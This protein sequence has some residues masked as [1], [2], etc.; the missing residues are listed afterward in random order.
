MVVSW[1]VREIWAA[2]LLSSLL[3]ACSKKPAEAPAPSK[4]PEPTPSAAPA[5]APEAKTGTAAA[6][7]QRPEPEEHPCHYCAADA[8]RHVS[9]T[10]QD[11]TCYPNKAGPVAYPVSGAVVEVVAGQ[12]KGS[13]FPVNAPPGTFELGGAL[14]G[15]LPEEAK[16]DQW[17]EAKLWVTDAHGQKCSSTLAIHL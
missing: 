8:L 5:A 6:V 2:L 15:T 16:P 12:Q 7:G 3:A 10:W 13:Q 4:A 1:S 17:T 11:A 14:D 9:G